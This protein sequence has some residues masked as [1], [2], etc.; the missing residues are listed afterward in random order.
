MAN[1]AKGQR[2]CTT[3]RYAN[4]VRAEDD[5]DLRNSFLTQVTLL[6]DLITATL[7]VRLGREGVGLATFDLLSA[8]RAG[9]GQATQAMVARRLGI[10]PA[11][12][13]EAVRTATAKGLIE[14]ADDPLDRRAKR[15]QLTQRGR[16]LLEDSLAELERVEETMLD[17]LSEAR[18]QAAEDV[19]RIAW[20]NL[21]ESLAF[22]A[23]R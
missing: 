14:Q 8:V 23:E 13:C 17:G 7:E 2:P 22:R 1:V 11:S 15:L 3:V 19:L 16:K 5:S 6:S 12:L 21:S 10:T 20:R 9:G 4:D 18:I